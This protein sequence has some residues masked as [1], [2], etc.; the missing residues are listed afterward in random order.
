M[1]HQFP[2]QPSEAVHRNHGTAKSEAWKR[3]RRANADNQFVM[4]PPYPQVQ[5]S[6]GNRL[7]EPDNSAG[8]LGL[9]PPELRRFGN[10]RPR[11]HPGRFPP[12][13]GYQQSELR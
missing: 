2:S 9:C 6:N 7:P 5:M 11:S 4:Q 10:D 8:I 12:G 13:Q 3:R 1:S